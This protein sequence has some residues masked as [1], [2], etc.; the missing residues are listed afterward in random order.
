MS[1]SAP[2]GSEI[3][4][5]A[6]KRRKAGRERLRM[7]GIPYETKNYGI[8]VVIRSGRFVIDYWP[9]PGKWTVRGSMVYSRDEDEMIRVCK[10]GLLYAS[11][12]G[13]G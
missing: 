10:S 6:R 5:A 2:E 12:N 13:L 4:K 7:A 8:H 9:N 1:E 3:R 11:I